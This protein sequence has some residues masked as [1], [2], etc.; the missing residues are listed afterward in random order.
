ML[1]APLVGLLATMVRTTTER[2]VEIPPIRVPRMRQ[3]ANSTVAAVNRTVCQIRMF[4]QDGIERDLILT[5]ERIG[6]VVLMPIPP[7]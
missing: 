4:A 7:K 2:T 6:A 3:K 1:P 5:N